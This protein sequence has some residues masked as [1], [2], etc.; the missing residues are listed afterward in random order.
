VSHAYTNGTFK[1]HSDS[2]WLAGVG[3]THLNEH[4]SAYAK[5][6]LTSNR[7]QT[8]AGSAALPEF[9]RLTGRHGNLV[10]GGLGLEYRW[11]EQL[12]VAIEADSYGKSGDR[13][14][15]GLLSVDLGWH[16]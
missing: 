9:S 16:F 2:F 10:L 4:W 15:N 11:N 14:N 1:G 12:S 3:R 13:S 8:D 5:A 7:T 6:M